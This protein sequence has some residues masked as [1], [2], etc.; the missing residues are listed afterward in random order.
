MS[1]VQRTES[2]AV[3]TDPLEVNVEQLPHP[4]KTPSKVQAAA[5]TEES[6]LAASTLPT[7]GSPQ[8]STAVSKRSL[9]EIDVSKD[10]IQRLKKEGSSLNFLPLSTGR[11]TDVWWHPVGATVYERTRGSTTPA[12]ALDVQFFIDGPGQVISH[13]DKGMR[14]TFKS[15]GTE[16]MQIA[17]MYHCLNRELHS[18]RRLSYDE[19]FRMFAGKFKIEEQTSEAAFA[20]AVL[21]HVLDEAITRI[22]GSFAIFLQKKPS[23]KIT[24]PADCLMEPNLNT[25]ACEAAT[26]FKYELRAR[27]LMCTPREI[28]V[29]QILPIN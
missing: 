12:V 23:A 14:I 10:L 22:P 17:Y 1:K 13:Q 6:S 4:R 27:L 7:S 2:V 11:L 8:T 28:E 18:E 3:L 16:T 26:G 19:W 20:V 21:N 29:R 9:S 24:Y 25:F 15:N 5:V